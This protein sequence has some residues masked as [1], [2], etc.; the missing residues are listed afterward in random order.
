MKFRGTDQSTSQREKLVPC[1]FPIVFLTATLETAA[2][3]WNMFYNLQCW[4]V[5]QISDSYLLEG[6]Y[7][8]PAVI[9]S[10][11]GE[12]GSCVCISD[13]V[14]HLSILPFIFIIGSDP[15]HSF[16]YWS[17]LWNVQLVTLCNSNTYFSM[18]FSYYLLIIKIRTRSCIAVLNFIWFFFR[19]TKGCIF[20][21][22]MP[23]KEILWK[24]D[25]FLLTQK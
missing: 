6:N 1:F 20:K 18:F 11:D 5:C 16:S 9:I 4:P 22:S 21:I 17:Q 24:I 12:D 23:Q 14:G 8:L 25:W 19:E 7:S 3:T 2:H 13:A 15:T 10:G